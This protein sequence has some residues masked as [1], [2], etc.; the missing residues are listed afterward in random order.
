M[1]R[2]ALAT[3]VAGCNQVLGLEETAPTDAGVLADRDGDGVAD[4]VDNCPD[5]ANEMQRDVDG[6]GIGDACDNCPI[7]SNPRQENNGELGMQDRVGDVCDPAPRGSLDCLLLL[8]VFADPNEFAVHWDV[9]PPASVVT[10]SAGAVLVA[11]S[12]GFVSVMSKDLG[13][14]VDAIEALTV[15][16]DLYDGVAA[17]AASTSGDLKSGL[18]CSLTAA[19]TGG[20]LAA[21]IGTNPA[22]FNQLSSD[23]VDHT[24]VLRLESTPAPASGTAL[25]CRADFGVAVATAR[26]YTGTTFPIGALDGVFV[27]GNALIIHAVA[28]YGQAS[29]CPAP[30]IR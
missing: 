11:A 17:L 9:Q 25:Q 24:L 12:P 6:D 15:K 30:I 8:D 1:W 22:N 4:I 14:E 16:P 28:M 18:L 5:D 7:I 20:T 19:S 13:V 23:P 29:P 2:V 10:P 27:Q 21:Q 3:L 26:A